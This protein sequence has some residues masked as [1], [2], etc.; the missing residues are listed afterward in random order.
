MVSILFGFWDDLY[1]DE[2]TDI[3]RGLCSSKGDCDF[4]L[5]GCDRLAIPSRKDGLQ[6]LNIVPD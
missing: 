4:G 1:L 3:Y 6:Q 5:A 2:R